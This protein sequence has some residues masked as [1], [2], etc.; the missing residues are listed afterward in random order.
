MVQLVFVAKQLRNGFNK[1]DT[2]GLKE[3]LSPYI[4]KNRGESMERRN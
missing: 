2:G 1:T 3:Y 4:W